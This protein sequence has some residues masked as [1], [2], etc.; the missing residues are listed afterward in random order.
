[1][2][3]NHNTN[4]FA[5]ACKNVGTKREKFSTSYPEETP[6]LG[7]GVNAETRNNGSMS[8]NLLE[9]N[10]VCGLLKIGRST[11]YS[12]VNSKAIKAVKLLGRTLFRESDIYEFVTALPEYEGGPNGF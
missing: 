8:C 12:L 3:N 9:F 1:M 10:E 7:L 11:L 2:K 5:N 6:V 4:R